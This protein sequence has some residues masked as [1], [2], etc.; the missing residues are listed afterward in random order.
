M[1]TKLPS[2]CVK[3]TQAYYNSKNQHSLPFSGTRVECVE[4]IKKSNDSIYRLDHNEISRWDLSIVNTNDLSQYKKIFIN[5]GTWTD[6]PYKKNE[7]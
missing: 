6:K 5:F 7:Y 4:F 2:H 1:K 3:A